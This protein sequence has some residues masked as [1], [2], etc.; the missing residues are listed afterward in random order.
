[1]DWIE[2]KKEKPRQGGVYFASDG[3]DIMICGYWPHM[4][5]EW[6][7]HNTNMPFKPTHWMQLPPPP[8]S[9]VQIGD[10]HTKKETDC[11]LKGPLYYG[12]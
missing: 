10:I 6:G 2:L 12:N 3:D 8:N 7:D 11:R 5:P 1:V 4:T 9:N